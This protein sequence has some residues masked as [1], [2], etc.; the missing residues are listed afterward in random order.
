MDNALI[1]NIF[2]KYYS[3]YGGAERIAYR[4]AD[5]LLNRGVDVRIYCGKNKIDKK[6]PYPVTELG[7]GR[8]RYAKAKGFAEK[9]ARLAETLDGVIF[10]FE[11]MENAHIFRPG[12]GVHRFF[13]QYTMLGISGFRR[14]AKIIKRKFDRV[15]RLNPVLERAAFNSPSLKFV[16]ANSNRMKREI[17]EDYP[18]AAELVC[19]IHNGVNKQMF[20][21]KRRD[22]LRENSDLVR[23]G[24]ATSNFQRKGLP[25]LIKALSILPD[26]FHL[27]VAGGRNPEPYRKLAKE[28]KI[29]NRITFL[30]KITE[31]DRF[32]ANLDV[33]CL[34]TFFDGF[35]N[36]VSEAI[37]TGIP[38]ACS[39]YSGSDEIIEAGVNGYVFQEVEP[40]QIAE[41]V[42]GAAAIGLKDFSGCVSTDEEV[43]DKYF[44]LCEKALT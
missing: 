35:A 31:M 1:V 8:T 28:L 9:G 20:N 23:I 2:I 4:F 37:A 17:V 18:E 30:G 3:E 44:E 29:D 22:E 25:Q 32:Y 7:L 21:P 24:L 10:S 42:K 12:G 36:V 34:P 5:Y 6:L 39:I 41:A 33:F 14:W 16:I 43:F 38:V 26:N 15:N 11:R 19:V 27:Y 40:L 13:T